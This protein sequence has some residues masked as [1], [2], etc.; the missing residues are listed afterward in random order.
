MDQTHSFRGER[1]NMSKDSASGLPTDLVHPCTKQMV[2]KGETS[3]LPV[4][5]SKKVDKIC[6]EM[7]MR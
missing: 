2:K 7:V 6:E 5:K 3:W 1:G 4:M